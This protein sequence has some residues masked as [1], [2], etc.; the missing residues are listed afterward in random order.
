MTARSS[1][2]ALA[3][4]AAASLGA[5]DEPWSFVPAARDL[6]EAGA[7]IHPLRIGPENVLLVGSQAPVPAGRM[8]GPTVAIRLPDEP[9]PAPARD[10]IPAGARWPDPEGRIVRS[11]AREAAEPQARNPWIAR[12]ESAAGA[13][14]LSFN[15]GGVIAGGRGAAFLNGRIVHVGDLPS[16]FRVAHIVAEGAVLERNG[17][18]Y[19]LPVGRT[20]VLADAGE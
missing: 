15:C 14:Q 1:M 17:E 19:V 13:R 7:W 8:A 9:E 16:G 20:T 5:S 3:L 10:L 12:G 11:P 18:F 4:S 2:L 6:P